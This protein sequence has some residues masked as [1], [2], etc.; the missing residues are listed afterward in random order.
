MRILGTINIVVSYP[1]FP[2][3]LPKIKISNFHAINFYAVICDFPHNHSINT[4]IMYTCV[5]VTHRRVIAVK[6]IKLFR[7]F[8]NGHVSVIR[9][10]TIYFPL[11]FFF[12]YFFVA[13]KKKGRI[14]FDSFIKL[15]VSFICFECTYCR[16]KNLF[17]L[18]GFFFVKFL[19]GRI[20]N[21]FY[22]HISIK[23][24]VVIYLA[25]LFSSIRL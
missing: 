9:Q 20:K 25:F 7:W 11:Y 22:F 24:L 23:N 1:N 5:E 8:V 19:N 16:L 3:R 17:I 18:L 2:P 10:V 12:L 13:F 6:V 21:W 15:R 14:Q 4:Y